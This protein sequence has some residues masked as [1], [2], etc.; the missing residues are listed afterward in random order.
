MNNRILRK[1][2]DD[3]SNLQTSPPQKKKEQKT[4]TTTTKIFIC[5]AAI[6]NYYLQ[7]DFRGSFCCALGGFF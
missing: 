7:K 1:V 2:K 3:M 5:N 6:A 4:T